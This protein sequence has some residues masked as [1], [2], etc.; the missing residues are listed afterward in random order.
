MASTVE[1]VVIDKL[2]NDDSGLLRSDAISLDYFFPIVSKEHSAFIFTGSGVQKTETST[3]DN[4]GT[5]FLRNSE[6]K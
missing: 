6:E 2:E 4:G 5:K 3:L 1:R